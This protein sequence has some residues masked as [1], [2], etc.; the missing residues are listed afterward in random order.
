VVSRIQSHG[1]VL[2]ILTEEDS[3]PIGLRPE[4]LV[5]LERDWMR[6]FARLLQGIVLKELHEGVISR[7]DES[8]V[9]VRYGSGEAEF[10]TEYPRSQFEA[11]VE[12]S[13]GDL[14]GA[15][16]ALWRLPAPP[17]SLNEFLTPEQER[18]IDEEWQQKRGVTGDVTI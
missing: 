15:G 7:I 18:A 10:E 4:Y 5:N 8:T 11:D 1:Q 12:L 9:T 16:I 13:R 2:D 3:T 14:I 6:S 17:T